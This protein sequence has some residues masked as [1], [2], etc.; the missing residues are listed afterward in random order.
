[1]KGILIVGG[2]GTFGTHVAR[3][4]A[5]DGL[6]V[7]IAGRDRR[8]AE[9]FATALGPHCRGAAVDTACPDSCAAALE[10]HSVVVNCAGPFG[11]FDDTLLRA[12]LD[13]GCHYADIG[14]DRGYAARVRALDDRFRARGLAAVYGCSSLPGISGALA[15]TLRQRI[16]GGIDRVRVT[17]FIGNR[18]PKGQAAVRSLLGGLG[19]PIAAPQGM[20]RG[21]HD[22][23]VVPLPS[24]FGCRTVFNFDSPD[25]D[26]LPGLVGARSVLVKVGFELR[27]ATAVFALLA[28]LGTGYG[29]CTARLLEF[30][31]WVFHRVGCSGG[32]VMTEFRRTDGSWVRATMLARGDGQRMVALP[33]ALVARELAKGPVIHHGAAT[34]YEFLG[35][36]ALL[37]ALVHAG[38]ELKFFE[39]ARSVTAREK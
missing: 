2:Y 33:C 32:A 31:A 25:Y 26:L 8:R 5:A 22:G 12:A 37:D 28:R 14:D 10:G 17:L 21:F 11:E 39:N 38:F 15:L 27:S 4:L 3:E 1:M 23:E 16:R 7:T 36:T 13:S 30:P 24:P 29:A 6:P 18:N 35:A 34:A 9:A 19:R 20:L